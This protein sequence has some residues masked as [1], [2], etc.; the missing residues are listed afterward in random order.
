[1]V[2][3]PL[4]L[5]VDAGNTSLTA[6][7]FRGTRLVRQGRLATATALERGE[8][9]ARLAACVGLGSLRGPMAAIFASVVPALDRKLAN[10]A[11]DRFRC[12]VFAV[13]PSSPLGLPLRVRTPREVG[14]DRIVNALAARELVGAPA[15]VVDIGTAVTVDCVTARGE[16]AG[17]AI[18]PGPGTAAEALRDRTAK[19]P[20]VE[21]ERATRAIGKDTSEC[22]RAGLYFGCLGMIREVVE[23]T[24][25]EMGGGRIRIILTGGYAPLYQRGLG[26]EFCIMPDLTLQ[27]LMLAHG[28]LAGGGTRC[29]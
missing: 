8:L 7:L 12:P 5:A 6:G 28:I 19:L 9:G 18:M 2:Q 4:L 15:V 10:A 26:P 27:G 29:Q 1:M 25:A 23:R 22:I 16:Y 13:T 21:P 11:A 14:A 20:Y 24:L 17:G 3:S